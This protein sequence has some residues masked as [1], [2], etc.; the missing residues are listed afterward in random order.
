MKNKRLMLSIVLIVLVAGGAIA[1]TYAYFTAQRTASTNR[2]TA[3]TLDL[4][5]TS[6]NTANDPFV[7]D[8]VGE[9]GDITGE[10]T[11]TIKN[12]GSLPGRLMLRL[13]NVQNKDN[14]CNDQE[15]EFEAN[16]EADDVGEMGNVLSLDVD[17]DGT[18]VASTALADANEGDLGT[19]WDSLTPIVL[20]PNDERTIRVHWN[21]TGNDYDNSIQSDS[22]SFDMNFRL[23]QQTN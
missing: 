19:A 14:G 2:F 16:C 20:Q 18:Q 7:V 8:N 1:G 4:N 23:I 21:A 11:Y 12:T 10:K 9:N 15:K 6:N 5:V 17:L 3:G 22:V 13:Q